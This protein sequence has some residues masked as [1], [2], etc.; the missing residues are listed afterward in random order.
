MKLRRRVAD[1]VGADAA[2]SRAA[3]DHDGLH[4]RDELAVDCGAKPAGPGECRNAPDRVTD[5]IFQTKRYLNLL[6][7]V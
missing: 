5:S 3:G 2:A 7:R 4:A 1:V 6:D